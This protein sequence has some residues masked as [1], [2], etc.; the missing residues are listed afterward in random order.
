MCIDDSLFSKIHVFEY[1]YNGYEWTK[2]TLDTIAFNYGV[3]FF[4]SALAVGDARN[5]G[6]NRV[7]GVSELGHIF[8]W[9]WDD[10]LN[11]VEQEDLKVVNDLKVR[12][13]LKVKPN[14]FYSYTAISNLP[15]D[16]ELKIYDITGRLVE[17]TNSTKVGAKLKTG[18]YFVTAGGYKPAKMVKIK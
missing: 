17:K 9:E 14:P 3:N 5:D 8:E 2:D 1:S 4:M 12:K 11:G 13:V 16:V 18:V 7:Y 6:K 10:S 15:S